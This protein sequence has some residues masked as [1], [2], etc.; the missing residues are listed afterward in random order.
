MFLNLLDDDQKRAFAALASKIVVADDTVYAEEFSLMNIL[1]A[2][3]GWDLKTSQ[4]DMAAIDAL[5][6]RAFRS[7]RSRIIALLELYVVALAE[8]KLPPEE[9]AI[10]EEVRK[11]FDFDEAEGRSL[12]AWARDITPRIL[13]GWEM[14]WNED[15]PQT[16]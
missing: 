11:A 12:L 8:G 10:L 6:L 1:H 2:E 4:A 3:I 5:L 14:V 16:D 7:R 15:V 13:E 9:I